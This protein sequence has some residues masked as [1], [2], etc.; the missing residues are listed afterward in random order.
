MT[1]YA[2]YSKIYTLQLYMISDSKQ[3][4]DF[5]SDFVRKVN[6]VVMITAASLAL[7]I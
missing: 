2:I 5:E 1:P 4:K 7:I 3:T 6:V